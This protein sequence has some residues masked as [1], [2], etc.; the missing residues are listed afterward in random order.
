MKI[1]CTHAELGIVN[2]YIF[3]LNVLRV[4]S[5]QLNNCWEAVWFKGRRQRGECESEICGFLTASGQVSTALVSVILGQVPYLLSLLKAVNLLPGV[6]IRRANVSFLF[7]MKW[8]T[9][10][11]NNKYNTKLKY[12]KP[13]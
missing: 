9:S 6:S 12:L 11:I 3:Q 4:Q 10:I 1:Q 2:K 13:I 7:K 5:N 8:H